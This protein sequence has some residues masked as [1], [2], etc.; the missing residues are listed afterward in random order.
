MLIPL[1]AAAALL[2]FDKVMNAL[3][4]PTKHTRTA[5]FR[6]AIVSLGDRFDLIEDKRMTN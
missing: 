6:R 1:L 3:M 2:Q 5:S 4:Q